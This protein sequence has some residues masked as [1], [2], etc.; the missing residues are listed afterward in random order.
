M[1]GQETVEYLTSAVDNLELVVPGLLEQC[2][3]SDGADMAAVLLQIQQARIKLQ[4]VERYVELECAMALTGDMTEAP[5]LRIERYR[6]AE[7]KAWDHESWQRDVR[8]KAL[9]KAGLLAAHVISADGEEV[10]AGV[11][12]EVLT[13]VQ[14]VHGAT[15]PKVG[16][17]RGL[18]L[19]PDDYC[20]RSP[21][22]W[23]VK[24]HT[25]VDETATEGQTDAA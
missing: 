25:V 6:S 7:R 18:G 4:D 14:S 20:E 1:S 8:N 21:G 23:H 5:G 12:H 17:I 9:R 22:A 2:T 10:P 3:A 13:W 16:S 19:D 24:V 11:L 15:G